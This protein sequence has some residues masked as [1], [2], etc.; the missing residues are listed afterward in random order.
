MLVRAGGHAKPLWKNCGVT[1]PVLQQLFPRCLSAKAK[2]ASLRDETAAPDRCPACSGS[3]ERG[4]T[5]LRLKAGKNGEGHGRPD[6]SDGFSSVEAPAVGG[7]RDAGCH[8]CV[9]P[10][11]PGCRMLDAAQRGASGRD[12]AGH[13][14]GRFRSSGDR[15]RARHPGRADRLARGPSRAAP[16]GSRSRSTSTS[17]TPPA[18]RA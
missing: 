17:P 7:V 16:S 4:D 2:Q 8:G 18:S 3:A 12:P 13:R 14:C 10:P 5:N 15:R 9:D 1:A 11:G 6:F